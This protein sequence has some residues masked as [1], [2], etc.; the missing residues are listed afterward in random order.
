MSNILDYVRFR[1]DLDFKVSPF[2][3][4]D[5][6]ILTQL[7]FIDL[8][9]VVKEGETPTL[10]E[11][12]PRFFE[13]N[14]RATFRLGLYFPIGM[15]ELLTLAARSRRFGAIRLL[16]HETRYDPEK[17]IQ[18]A[19]MSYFLPDK[20]IYVAYRGTDDSLFGWYESLSLG[21]YPELPIH[22][23]S[24]AYLDRILTEYRYRRVRIGGHSK[25][26]HLALYAALKA[27]RK[28]YR[29]IL[30]VYNVDG[31]GF[32][33]DLGA[34]EAYSALSDRI[35][36]VTPYISI[37]GALLNRSGTTDV[38]ASDGEGVFQH[39]V[40][41]WHV[42]GT[43]LV[44]LNERSAESYRVE[45]SIKG[46]LAKMSDADKEKALDALYRLFTASGAKTL[47]EISEDKLNSAL[48]FGKVLLTLDK[49]TRSA[50]SRAVMLL[51]KE[52]KA[53]LR[54]QKDE[55]KKNKKNKKAS[56]SAAADSD[57]E[58]S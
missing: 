10:S 26:G 13:V 56:E 19:A 55:A 48:S 21:V 16:D 43:S 57:G 34:S 50:V 14:D 41:N 17:K 3:E 51:L 23:L 46:W 24:T 5:S 9:S 28:Y 45:K 11:I 20:T 35:Y 7:T 47:S 36:S 1:G 18:F 49:E 15:G 44:R 8:G 29:R 12:E 2:N 54:Q 40:F 52:R 25:G 33:D 4:I 31:P 27:D 22:R 58:E 39:D 38:V 42:E 30:G 37:V 6:L 53:V 32:L